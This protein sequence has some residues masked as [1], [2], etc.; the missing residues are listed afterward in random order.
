M[1][2]IKARRIFDIAIRTQIYIEGV[3]AN[4]SLEFNRV[5]VEMNEEFKKILNL[6]NYETLDGLTKAELNRLVVSLR[7]SQSKIYSAYLQKVLKQLQEFM[8]ACLT[9]NRVVYAYSLLNLGEDEET[10]KVPSDEK[11]SKL[12]QEENK[13]NNLI[14]VWG[15]AS[16]LYGSDSLWS[17]ILND[18]IA[19]NGALINPFLKSFS[20]SAQL[21]FE[22]LIRKGYSNK[23][24]VSQTLNQS[25]IQ[26][27]KISNQ[28]DAILA[29]IMQHISG[30]V[31]SAVASALYAKYRW[32]SI[33]DSG[34]TE[35][36]LS[37]NNKVYFYGKGPVTPAH[38]RCRSTMI[39]YSVQHDNETFYA[40]IKRQ[41][42]RTQNFALGRNV[43][44]L[45]RTGKIASKDLIRLANPTPMTI[46]QFKKAG[47]E[48]IMGKSP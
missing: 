6:V 2:I 16:I 30:A 15:I 41:P 21:S 13:K 32:V 24:S 19:A 23:W 7:Q 46:A 5:L 14:P 17:K 44:N 33:I 3:K 40:W 37:R 35:I 36:C 18:P 20:I 48:I 42:E 10:E 22:N 28:S 34:T 12:I 26:N 9:V 4:Q 38:I 25:N 27:S 43:A 45:L 47:I 8:Q 31:S 29:T 11:A 39:P 1:S